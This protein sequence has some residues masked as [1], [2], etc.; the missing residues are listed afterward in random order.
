MPKKKRKQ[1]KGRGPKP[2]KPATAATYGSK[3]GRR[4][5]YSGG[6]YQGGSTTVLPKVFITAEARKALD[7]YIDLVDVEV[8]GLGIV[9][10]YRSDFLIEEIHL[11]EQQVSYSSTDLDQRAIA[12]LIQDIVAKGGDAGKLRLWWHSH[13]NMQSYWSAQ[14]ENCIAGF[15]RH[16]SDWMIS[17]V[18]NHRMDYVARL[19]FFNPVRIKLDRLQF[20]TLHAQAGEDED[21]RAALQAEIDAKVRGQSPRQAY[22]A[23]WFPGWYGEEEDEGEDDGTETILYLPNPAASTGRPTTNG[24]TSWKPGDPKIEVEEGDEEGDPVI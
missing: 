15:G 21:Y 9:S 14:D 3:Y 13:G 7:T 19:D 24:V 23:Q 12:L 2:K 20:E 22:M 5:G 17:V 1:R 4:S 18:G 11:L 10:R 6:Y 8:G 16:G